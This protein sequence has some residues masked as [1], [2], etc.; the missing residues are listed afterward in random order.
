MYSDT[1]VANERLEIL[2]MSTAELDEAISR[3]LA[4]IRK[5]PLRW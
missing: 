2:P 4:T 5:E 1:T 3:V